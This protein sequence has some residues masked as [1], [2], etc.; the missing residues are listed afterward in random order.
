ML[1]AHDINKLAPLI[2]APV[3]KGEICAVIVSYNSPESV[4]SCIDSLLGQ[5][6]EIIVV[7]NSANPDV[8]SIFSALSYHEKVVFIFMKRIGDSQPP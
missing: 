7:D 4:I 5:V 6:A 8:T 1:Y 3:E 2:S